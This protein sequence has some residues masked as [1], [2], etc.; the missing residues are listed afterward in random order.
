MPWHDLFEEA[1]GNGR[2]AQSGN[3]VYFS[4]NSLK[5]LAM[6]IGKTVYF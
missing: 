6:S 3:P 5:F 4:F 2:P 1:A